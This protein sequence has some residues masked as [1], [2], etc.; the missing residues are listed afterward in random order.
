LTGLLFGVLAA[1][2]GLGDVVFTG[3]VNGEQ[4]S[5][6]GNGLGA[7]DEVFITPPDLPAGPTEFDPGVGG[8][9]P[10]LD[11]TDRPRQIHP[12]TPVD[13]NLMLEPVETFTTLEESITAPP[14]N[15]AHVLENEPFNGAAGSPIIVIPVE[16]PTTSR[17]TSTRT[18][19]GIFIR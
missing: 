4:T 2:G 6:S 18:R 15:R 12:G 1:I 9:F 7:D 14:S 11:V 17:R 5:P 3:A 10:G 13:V 16:M 8:S 19:H